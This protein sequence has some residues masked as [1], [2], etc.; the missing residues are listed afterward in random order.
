MEDPYVEY[1]TKWKKIINYVS[2]FLFCDKVTKA[3]RWDNADAC[4]GSAS[5]T[6]SLVIDGITRLNWN[7]INNKSIPILTLKYNQLEY[8][9]LYTEPF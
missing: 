5:L 8:S 4:D 9:S 2:T 1:A 7:C 3:T 6:A